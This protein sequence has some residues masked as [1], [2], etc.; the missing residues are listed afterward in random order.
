MTRFLNR[1]FKTLITTAL[2]VLYGPLQAWEEPDAARQE[3]IRVTV[4]VTD[5]LGMPLPYTTIAFT[6]ADN[7]IFAAVSDKEGSTLFS[8]HEDSYVLT[9]EYIG[10]NPYRRELH[11]SQHA[12]T[13]YRIVMHESAVSI[14]DVVV[15]ASETKGSTSS[16]TIDRKAMEHLQPS[17]FAD[18]LSLLPGGTATKPLLGSP[19]TIH[20]R[21]TG[22]SSSDY[23][24]SALGTSFVIDGA[25]VS[26]DAN[27]Q[28][29]PGSS[30]FDTEISYNYFVNSGVDMRTISTDQIESVEIVRG[31]PSV[32]YGDLTSGL[33]KIKR[34][35]GGHQLN[36]RF[37][38]DMASKLFYAGKGF[39]IPRR[40]LTVNVG[41]DLL[42]AKSDPRNKL[43]NFKRVTGSLRVDKKWDSDTHQTSLGLHLDYTGSFDNKKKD[44]E[45]NNHNIDDYKSQYNRLNCGINFEY[46]AK[47][48][49]FF[50]S[51]ESTASF[52]YSKDLIRRRRFVSISKPM[53][54]PVNMEAGEFDAVPIEASYTA[55]MTVDGRPLSAFVKWMASFAFSTA[56]SRSSIVAGADWSLDKNL[57]RGQV[58][59]MTRPIFSGVAARP[60]PYNKIPA[61]HDL[62]MFLEDNT[63]LTMGRT[64][65]DIMAGLRVLTMFNIAR[66]YAMH[67]DF[68]FDPRVNLRLSLPG[69][70]IAGHEV[71]TALSGGMG[72]HTKSPTMNQLYPAPRYYDFMQLNYF[73]TNAALRRFNVRTYITDPTNYRLMPARNFKWEVRGD[74]TVAGNRLSLTYFEEDMKS[75]FRSAA[76]YRKYSYKAY[77]YSGIDGSQLMEPPSLEQMPY[78]TQNVLRSY[79]ATTNGSRTSKK[80]VEFTFSSQ[81]IAALRTRVTITGAWFRTEYSN[82]EPIHY[83]PSVLIDNK[84]L[85]Y[86]GIYDDDSHYIRE[87]CNTNF[88]VDTDLPR[89]GLGFSLTFQC[90]WLTRDLNTHRSSRPSH[91]TDIDGN[92]FPFTEASEQDPYLKWLIIHYNEK[93]FRWHSVPF[94][95]TTNLKVTKR[96][97]GEKLSAAMFITQ[98]LNY[99]PDYKVEG[100]TVRRSATPYFGMELNFKL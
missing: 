4:E 50:R 7:H 48:E 19:N 52:D 23:A 89:I 59:D 57:G 77:D 21:E 74:V 25:P 10:Y 83:S 31:I 94:A 95:M 80:G 28:Y 71:T 33:V 6:D 16:S 29:I 46:R 18:L 5:S 42:D 12:P 38:A 72:W 3:K 35:K 61:Q 92:S 70:T 24:T 68:W 78:T 62:G 34:R 2:L 32:Q 9:A 30:T 43:E 40:N 85:G 17:S 73:H 1:L 93:S 37:K 82:S 81:R 91:Y 14:R 51:L 22:V 53:V 54:T 11:L 90:Q 27:M 15:T 56:R 67:G 84:E 20:L 47:G 13:L 39:E 49:G 66:K 97:M 76:T 36:A 41:A 69:F 55:R 88:M 60:Y 65:L 63:T 8:L 44:P 64:H 99:T 26:T 87:I 45:L 96:L 75:G 79:S 98:M 100:V 58:F 86:V